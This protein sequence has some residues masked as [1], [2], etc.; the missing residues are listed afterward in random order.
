MHHGIHD[1]YE[2]SQTLKTNPIR[3]SLRS[4]PKVLSQMDVISAVSGLALW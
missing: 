3:V 4:F 1:Q 2:K